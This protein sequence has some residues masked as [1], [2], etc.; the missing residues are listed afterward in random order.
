VQARHHRED[1]AGEAQD[2]RDG[3]C[4]HPLAQAGRFTVDIGLVFGFQFREV[5]FVGAAW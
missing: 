5:G 4:R 2:H 3:C 1:H